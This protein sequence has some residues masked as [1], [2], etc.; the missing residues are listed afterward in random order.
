LKRAGIVFNVKSAGSHVSSSFHVTGAETPS[1]VQ[2]HDARRLTLIGTGFAAVKR[3]TA[4]DTELD[5]RLVSPTQMDVFL[6]SQLTK[7]LKTLTVL[8]WN[9]RGTVIGS[10]DVTVR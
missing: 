2:R 3:V 1:I 8:L 5:S 9:D 4:D 6:Q 7:E 10:V